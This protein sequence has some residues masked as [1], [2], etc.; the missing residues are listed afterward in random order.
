MYDT[1]KNWFHFFSLIQLYNFSPA[2]Y[3]E[4]VNSTGNCCEVDILHLDC[5]WPKIK[6]FLSLSVTTKPIMLRHALAID[7]S[8]FQIVIYTIPTKKNSVST[9]FLFP[10]NRFLNPMAELKFAQ[11]CFFQI[12]PMWNMLVLYMFFFYFYS[13]CIMFLDNCSFKWR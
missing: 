7:F 9:I 4:L 3:K 1:L 8:T 2:C 6:P 5:G 13:Y 12:V 10:R 11:S